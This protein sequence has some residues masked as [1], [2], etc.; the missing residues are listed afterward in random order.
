[1]LMHQELYLKGIKLIELLDYF[2]QDLKDHKLTERVLNCQVGQKTL[3]DSHLLY[4]CQNMNISCYRPVPSNTR[5][6]SVPECTNDE[7]YSQVISFNRFWEDAESQSGHGKREKR[8]LDLDLGSEVDKDLYEAVN[9]DGDNIKVLI[10]NQKKLAT[11]AD[12]LSTVITYNFNETHNFNKQI[13]RRVV[14]NEIQGALRSLINK[15]QTNVSKETLL[16]KILLS[17][18]HGWISRLQNKMNLLSKAYLG[19]EPCV[20][21]H[22]SNLCLINQE[23]VRFEFSTL[24]LSVGGI[25]D[26]IRVSEVER[27]F[28]VPTEKGMF[29]HAGEVIISQNSNKALLADGYIW[30]FK[31]K[32]SEFS[33]DLN[34]LIKWDGCYFTFIQTLNLEDHYFLASC[35]KKSTFKVQNEITHYDPWEKVVLKVTDFPV[36]HNSHLIKLEE[37]MITMNRVSI[38]YKNLYPPRRV[39]VSPV[40]FLN[41]LHEHHQ[42][43]LSETES[44][45]ADLM[46]LVKRR[47]QVAGIFGSLVS[48]LGLGVSVLLCYCSCKH[49]YCSRMFNYLIKCCRTT[50]SSSPVPSAPQG[51]SIPL[52]RKSSS[53]L[54]PST[55]QTRNNLYQGQ[56]VV[57]PRPRIES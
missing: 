21:V 42:V 11:R 57:V 22:S 3:S 51:E 29:L 19:S 10:R 5:S 34:G 37:L 20:N 17:K 53:K 44:L 46:E 55:Y 1:M 47:P 36:S 16:H 15:L 13:A 52:Q 7:L 56:N 31:L 23:F 30:D 35:E 40:Q 14:N 27:L 25:F 48:I 18:V 9:T 32:D 50:Q 41:L 49:G 4:L 26:S 6:L 43:E 39:H 33:W 45:T 12:E 8:F 24:T 54:R 38:D 2:T 28:C